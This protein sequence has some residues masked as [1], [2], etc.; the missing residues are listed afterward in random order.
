[1]APNDQIDQW[2]V[3][4]GRCGGLDFIHTAEARRQEA[5][6]A[7]VIAGLPDDMREALGLTPRRAPVLGLD[8]FNR[9]VHPEPVDL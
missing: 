6:A 3:E 7:D 2:H 5:E 1:M 9:L 4:C 8:E